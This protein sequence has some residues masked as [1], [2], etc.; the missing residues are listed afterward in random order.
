MV[1]KHIKILPEGL[2]DRIAAGEVIENPASVIKE[3]VENSLDA[4][5]KNIEISISGGGKE[6]IIIVDD[7]EVIPK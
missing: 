7:G 3:L 2:I 6:E 5:A 1:M 4:G